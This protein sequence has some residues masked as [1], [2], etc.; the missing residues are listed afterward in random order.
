LRHRAAGERLG[1][2]DAL[3]LQQEP[4]EVVQRVA[5]V[6]VERERAA[7]RRFR[8]GAQSLLH[9]GVAEV[10]PG[11]ERIGMR[12]EELAVLRRGRGVVAF[13]FQ[14]HRGADRAGDRI[15]RMDRDGGVTAARPR[16]FQP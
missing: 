14:R 8:F 3:L 13:F 9:F 11:E 12:G 4:G 5:R 7:E 1:F 6:A 15:A 2:V 16:F 10:R